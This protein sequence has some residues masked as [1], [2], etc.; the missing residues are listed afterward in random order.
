MYKFL[1]VILL[2]VA[3]GA[4]ARSHDFAGSARDPAST[5]AMAQERGTEPARKAPRATAGEIEE[6]V[7]VQDSRVWLLLG[8][9]ALG[10][11]A[12]RATDASRAQP[13]NQQRSALETLR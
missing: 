3:A 9:I 10:I 1:A 5:R 2:A 13:A 4:Q 7:T 8:A 11:A 12:Y 6:P